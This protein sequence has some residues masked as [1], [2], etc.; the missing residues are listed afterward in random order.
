MTT[1][2]GFTKLPADDEGRWNYVYFCHL[3]SAESDGDLFK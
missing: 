1:E 3:L 2:D